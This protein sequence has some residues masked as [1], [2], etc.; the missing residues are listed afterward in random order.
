MAKAVGWKNIPDE[1]K[2]LRQWCVSRYGHPVPK[3]RKAPRI[4]RGNAPLASITKPEEWG[5]FDEAAQYAWDHGTDEWCIGF[6]LTEKDPYCVIDLDVRNSTTHPDLPAL[7]TTKE[8]L[9]EYWRIAKGLDTYVE[10]S[11]SGVSLHVV[12]KA[13]IGQGARHKGIEVYS[14]G[15]YIIFTGD[16]VIN[17]PI[18][19]AQLEIETS[20]KSLRESQARSERSTL[21]E[22]DPCDTD[23]EVYQRARDAVNGDKFEEL[24]SGR[25]QQF[26]YPSQSEADLALMS[27][28]AFYSKSNEQCRRL[29]R[30]TQ[31][32]KREKAM[33]NNRY[34]NYNLSLIRA[35]Q[36]RDEAVDIAAL[37][38]QGSLILQKLRNLPP[39][40]LPPAPP[41]FLPGQPPLPPQP[42]PTVAT[43]APVGPTPP[44]PPTPPA[45]GFSPSAPPPPPPQATG[46][47]ISTIPWP[48]G[49]IGDVAN[50][51]YHNSPRP[52]REV[53]IVAAFGFFAGVCGKAYYLPQ[54][55]LNIYMV[56]VAQSAVGKEAMHSG[57]ASILQILRDKN[58]GI[59][60]FVDFSEF[61][62]GPALTKAC[63]LNQSFVNVSGEWGRK[64]K[65]FAQDEN[66]DSAIQSLRT[67]MTNLYQKSGP[68]S[69]V[70]GIAYSKKDESIKSV[71][72]VAYSM[73]GE[74]TPNTFYESLTESMM[75]DGFLSR[76]TMLEY[77]GK[78]PPLNL[79][80]PIPMGPQFA[81]RL[82]YLGRKARAV[83]DGKE[84]PIA[85]RWDQESIEMLTQFDKECDKMINSTNDEIWRQMWNRAHLKALRFSALMACADNYL[86]PVINI[87]HAMWAIDLIRR[88]IA[89]MSKKIDTGSVGI[90]DDAR[91][92][93]VLHILREY[94][95]QELPSSYGVPAHLRQQGVIPRRYI[96][97][98][99]ARVNSFMRH[100]LGST[101]ALDLTI[102][103][104]IDNGYIRE[105]S[106]ERAATEFE[107]FGRCYQIVDLPE[108]SN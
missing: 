80:P 21:Y 88:D 33:K 91:E 85:V 36:A 61:A 41:T 69:V 12:V 96:Q 39:V 5:T 50:F 6:V 4:P 59:D 10:K 51:I 56:L 78:R 49:V 43:G 57:I 95:T 32:G 44:A 98:K 106:R 58:C 71:S 87:N 84:E 20:V 62:S 65:R 48:P 72:G 67:V 107:F 86:N 74:T 16:V 7:W 63:L 31:L 73:I 81:D 76:F 102:R 100:R 101:G 29:F 42:A 93:R 66:A 26:G 34:L 13:S 38:R 3:Q 17:K 45:G 92:K 25:W 22:I 15:R 68:A 64:L 8:E 82:A 24:C 35:R 23:E 89:L 79:N 108:L 46:E 11:I 9:E 103:A 40:T 70:G 53:A 60:D 75:E 18:R 19:N 97:M 37:E 27:I 30:S 94:L 104:L 47:T 28:F 90:G 14:R 83:V 77:S 2:Q 105:F 55:G 52:V 99:T 54:S 1:L